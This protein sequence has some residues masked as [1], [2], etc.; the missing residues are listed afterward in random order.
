M[1]EF[2]ADELNE[3]LEQ[4]NRGQLANV[5]K[6]VDKLLKDIKGDRPVPKRSDQTPRSHGPADKGFKTS[7]RSR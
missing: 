1:A 3:R 4:L 2:D 6:L 7:R 5:E